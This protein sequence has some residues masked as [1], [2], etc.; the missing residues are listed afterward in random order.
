MLDV[1]V[2]DAEAVAD[3]AHL[4]VRLGAEVLR[5]SAPVYLEIGQQPVKAKRHGERVEI[6]QALDPAATPEGRYLPIFLR[7]DG[8]NTYGWMLER[9]LTPAT[10]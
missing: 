7:E 6:Y 9:Q 8:E 10:C 3:T 2:G 4:V 5:T 1:H